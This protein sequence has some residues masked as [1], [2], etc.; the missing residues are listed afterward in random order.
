M[1]MTSFQ[2]GGWNIGQGGNLAQ[3][4]GIFFFL[5]CVEISLTTFSFGL[6]CNAILLLLMVV[7]HLMYV[8]V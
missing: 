6:T 8:K 2:L 5:V 7:L 4:L 3:R 1:A